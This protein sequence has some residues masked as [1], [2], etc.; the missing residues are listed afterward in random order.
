MCNFK[1]DLAVNYNIHSCQLLR[2]FRNYYEFICELR[3]YEFPIKYYE[4]QLSRH[5]K[6]NLYICNAF[7]LFQL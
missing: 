6:K 4:F 3:K 2:V 1:A 5:G 7:I